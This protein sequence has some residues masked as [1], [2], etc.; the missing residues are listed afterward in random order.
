[1]FFRLFIKYIIRKFALN[2]FNIMEYTKEQLKEQAHVKIEQLIEDKEYRQVDIASKLGITYRTFWQRRRDT[3]W[4]G[5][6]VRI[7][8]NDL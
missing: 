7:I 8:L 2:N 1:M 5:K 6:E 3:T 4:T